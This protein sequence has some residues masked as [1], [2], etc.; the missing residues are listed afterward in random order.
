MCMRKYKDAESWLH[1]HQVL[2]PSDVVSISKSAQCYVLADGNINA[3]QARLSSIEKIN[4]YN[5]EVVTTLIL[6]D[7]FK[8]NYNRVLNL[9]DSIGIKA[10]DDQQIYL[11]K[12]CVKGYVYNIL[13]DGIKC[14]QY[15]DSSVMIINEEMKKNPSDPR[16]HS[17]LGIT[18][19]FQGKKNKTISAAK[20]AIEI[21]PV[22]LD[23]LDGPEYVNN[24]DWVYTIIGE[25]DKALEQLE[26][27]LSIPAGKV[28][29]KAK[30]KKDPKWDN[31]R[32]HPR[33]QEL[34]Q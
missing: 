9:F 18:Y 26:F 23:A 10:V 1:R 25:Y 34:I 32:N 12:Y 28:I 24:L 20:R 21:Y 17:A 6:I 31:L 27:L 15:A 14:R 11:D 13:G 5:G 22:S 33:F 2:V 30:L 16:Y 19:A 4:R 8:N 7:L 29:S 3:A